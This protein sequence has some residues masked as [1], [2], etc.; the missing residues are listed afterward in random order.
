M[1]KFVAFFEKVSNW[2][3]FILFLILYIIFP[4]YI[5]KNAEIKINELAGKEIGVIDLTMGFNPQKTLNMVADYGEEGRA[6]VAK[7]ETT[8]DIVYPIIYA[9]LFA[10]ILTLIYR[11]KTWAWVSIIP[12]ITMFFDFLENICIVTLL[13]SYPEQSSTWGTLCETFK[14]L[15]WVSFGII[16]LLIVYGLI[17][18]L[19]KKDKLASTNE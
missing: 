6:Y 13:N 9:F 18:K 11:N 8:A 5:L 4:G 1:Q 12:F 7:V 2:K 19:M 10:I 17:S 3:T 15:K 16:I 14:L